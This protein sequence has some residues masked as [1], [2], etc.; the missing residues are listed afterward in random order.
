MDAMV[1]YDLGAIFTFNVSVSGS[2]FIMAYKIIVIAIKPGLSR[3]QSSI[4]RARGLR[5]EDCLRILHN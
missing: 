1:W 2:C 4:T 3:S 5:L